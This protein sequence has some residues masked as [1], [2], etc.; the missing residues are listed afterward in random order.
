MEA[1]Y[2]IMRANIPDVIVPAKTDTEKVERIIYLVCGVTN[3]PYQFILGKSR[4]R[5]IV[6]VRHIAMYLVCWHTTLSLKAIGKIFNRDH[7]SVIHARD[8]VSDLLDT[9]AEFRY[10]FKSINDKLNLWKHGK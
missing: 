2:V 6:E 8:T 9:S 7:S 3:T 1:E 5:E 4:S 10:K